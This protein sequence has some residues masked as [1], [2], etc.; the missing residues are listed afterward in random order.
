MKKYK[1]ETNNIL[2]GKDDTYGSVNPSIVRAST[3]FYDKIEKLYS[4]EKN[5]LKENKKNHHYGRVGTTT[6]LQLDYILKKLE[7]S[8]Y[9]LTCPSGLAAIAL[10]IIANCKSGDEILITDSAYYPSK[11]ISNFL[12]KYNVN[13]VYYDPRNLDNLKSLITKKTKIL[14][15]ENPSSHTFEFQD[16]NKLLSIAKSKKVISVI[17]NTWSTAMLFKPINFGFDFSITA[18]TK[19]LSGHSDILIG[20]VAF[21]KKYAANMM[22]TYRVLGYHVSPDDAYLC[23]RG[24][25]TLDI[26]LKKH[27]ENTLKVCKFLKKQKK[28][29]R[30]FYPVGSDT[31]YKNWKK[32]YKGRTGLL[33]VAFLNTNKKKI[34]SAINSSKIFVK[35]YSWGGYESMVIPA[36]IGDRKFKYLDNNETLLRFH[37]GLEN[38]NDILGDLKNI[39][40]KI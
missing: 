14:F 32:Y 23:I 33:G 36:S 27:E 16:L 24:I 29:S 4:S 40:K 3:I 6:N 31:N 13:V 12:E 28:V 30:I 34:Y 21:N 37:I 20:S 5:I 2:L 35:G 22:R 10:T 9:V 1:D 8:E 7:K 18:G 15:V 11:A 26:R 25:R 17:D 19:Y 38:I 39:I